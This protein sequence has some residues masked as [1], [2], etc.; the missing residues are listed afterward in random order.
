MGLNNLL[1]TKNND[2]EFD[3]TNTSLKQTLHMYVNNGKTCETK[4]W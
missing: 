1:I 2:D 3:T 4:L